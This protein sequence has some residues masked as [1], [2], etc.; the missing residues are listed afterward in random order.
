MNYFDLMWSFEAI[1]Q[2]LSVKTRY[3]LHVLVAHYQDI[4]INWV[5][6]W[7]KLKEAAEKLKRIKADWFDN[8]YI[9][10]KS[11]EEISCVLLN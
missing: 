7:K 9:V 1:K 2:D 4:E 6:V 3:R 8:Y 5:D 10:G 11:M